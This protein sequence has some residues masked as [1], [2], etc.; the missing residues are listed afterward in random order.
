MGD[1]EDTPVYYVNDFEDDWSDAHSIS[2]ATSGFTG[3]KYFQQIHGRAFPLAP[4]APMLFPTD[5]AEVQRLDFLHPA[6]K[7]IL[8]GNY[9]GPV[10][11]VLSETGERR[12]R[13]LDLITA[14]GNW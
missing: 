11:D 8:N 9:Y 14:E 13:V 1:S 4:S 10:K 6:L 2:T 7:R 3:H 12:K 5:H